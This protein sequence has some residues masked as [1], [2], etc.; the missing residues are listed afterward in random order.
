MPN[1]KEVKQNVYSTTAMD[2]F[3]KLMPSVRDELEL[4]SMIFYTALMYGTKKD[5]TDELVNEI[6]DQGIPMRGRLCT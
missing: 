4:I 6:A 1:R 2:N 3:R 5:V